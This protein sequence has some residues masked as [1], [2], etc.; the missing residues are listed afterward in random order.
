MRLYS[1]IYQS[2]DPFGIFDEVVPCFDETQLDK[3][4][5]LLLHGGADISPS[6]YKEKANRFCYAKD[7][8]SDRDEREMRFIDKAQQLQIP[9]IGMCRGAQLLCA[10]SGGKLIQDVT[11]H[12]SREHRIST[13]EGY[14]IWA[15]SVHHQMMKPN[16][17]KHTLL[18]WCDPKLSQEYLGEDECNHN[19]DIEPEVVYFHELNA[20]AIQGHPEYLNPQ[21]PFVKYCTNKIKEYCL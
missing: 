19:M 18:A 16:G 5:V 7:K 2:K 10:V 3:D 9:I 14:K 20:L 4:G 12:E 17:T 8:P 1:A 13:K 11:G 6:I 15:N 21:V